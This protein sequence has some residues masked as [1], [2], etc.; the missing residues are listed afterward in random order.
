[1]KNLLLA[2]AAMAALCATS[3]AQ[4]SIVPLLNG[5]TAD[6]T[7]F[8]FDYTG[9][10][11]SDQGVTKGSKLIIYDFKG[12]VDG[13]IRSPTANILT[14]IELSSNLPLPSGYTDDPTI[15]NLVFT[16]NGADFDTDTVA[17]ADI[18]FGGLGADSIF[19]DMHPGAFSAVGVG[20]SGGSAGAPTFSEGAVDVA[21]PF[22]EPLA[23][24]AAIPEPASWSLMILGFGGLGALLR[25]RRRLLS[26]GA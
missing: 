5:V 9:T 19:H 22:E 10:L 6:G 11:S 17:A 8:R 14:S 7:N 25:D 20:N 1:M 12:Y 3:T 4:A 26:L 21:A 2:A 16:W 15:P 18:T 13:S 24:G 23:V